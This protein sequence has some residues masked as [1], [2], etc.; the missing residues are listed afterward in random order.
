VPAIDVVRTEERD[1]ASIIVDRESRQRTSLDKDIKSLA[2]QIDRA[3]LIHAIV[4]H[5]DGRLV[6]GERR[7][8]A[9]KLLQRQKI[10]C[11]IFES[12][13]KADAFL[14]ELQE[15]MARRQL[16]WQDEARAVENY[17]KM[18]KEVH[19]GWTLRATAQDLGVT[20]PVIQLRLAVAN[21]LTDAEV[22]GCQTLQGAFNLL[23]GR[24]ERATA[25]AQNRG[26]PIADV[27]PDILPA[28]AKQTAA[29]EIDEL[30]SSGSSLDDIRVEQPDPF[31]ILEAG[32]VAEQ[33]LRQQRE[34]ES[35]DLSPII[36]GDFLEWVRDYDGAKFDVLHLDF[37]YGKGYTGANTRKT[38]RAHVA[39]R[40]ADDP[41]VH[42][43]L[44]EGF[45]EH[46]EKIAFPIAH[47]IYWFDMDYY[48]AI[49]ES[50]ERAGWRT[51]QPHPLIWAK[52]YE[53]VAADPKRRP[54][55]CY[56][57][58]L[59]FSRGDRKLARLDQDFFV[60][61]TDEKLH[62]NQKPVDMLKHFLSLVVDE[63]SAV[64]DPTCGSGTALAAAKDLGAPRV[65][66]LELDAGNAEVARFVVNRS[67]PA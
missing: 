9:H 33:S 8:E 65:L 34:A 59:L 46:Q 39:P 42:W 38:G 12:L 52:P 5:E 20:E 30:I 19:G 24:A 29:A 13:P 55:H 50:F 64:L 2:E 4:I 6:A 45:L 3:G 49:R 37:P 61:R 57:T 23:K 28:A 66:G 48:A 26:L 44:L 43:A 35:D 60:G 7:L 21:H 67:V 17:H 56:E 14:I 22:A 18:K 53:G 1:V 62:I 63:H 15:N 11:T 58:A 25:A 41:D 32:K 40:Y 31:A 27:L 54:R 10:R 16:A 47:C 36:T 51:V